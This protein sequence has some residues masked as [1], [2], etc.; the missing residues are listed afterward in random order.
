MIACHCTIQL[1]GPAGGVSSVTYA[2]KSHFVIRGRQ[3]S[4]RLFSPERDG[5]RA[6]VD[7]NRVDE[8][9]GVNVSR[10]AANSVSRSSGRPRPSRCYISA[11][12]IITTAR[13][14]DVRRTRGRIMPKCT[15]YTTNIVC[16]IL[17]IRRV[18]RVLDDSGVSCALVR[19]D[20]HQYITT[21]SPHIHAS[22]VPATRAALTNP[23]PGRE[24][25]VVW[26][27]LLYY[28]LFIIVIT[29]IKRNFARGSTTIIL[30]RVLFAAVRRYDK[31]RG[32]RTT[33]TL[34]DF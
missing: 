23:S 21:P 3:K 33:G 32:S 8:R 34:S 12:S 7:V 27:L 19:H 9:K 11:T 5:G 18:R 4:V 22:S 15:L 13:V 26:S 17:F 2:D 31:F 29:V 20:A 25:Q 6:G 30:S 24:V 16:M 28:H 14:R 1:A 10:P